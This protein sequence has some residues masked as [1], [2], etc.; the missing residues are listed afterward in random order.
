MSAKPFVFVLMPFNDA[1]TDIYKLGIKK[2]AEEAGLR[3][4]RVD[5]QLYSE[6]MLE[7]IYRQIDAAD[8]VVADMTGQN[9]NVFYEVGY[10]H[11]KGKLCI[12]LTQNAS[13]I[14]FDLKQHRHIVYGGQIVRLQNELATNLQWAAEQVKS[15]KTSGLSVNFEV[16]NE[17]LERN[18]FQATVSLRLLIDIE[19]T[20]E[21]SFG[22]IESVTLYHG[23]RWEFSQNGQICPKTKSDHPLFA[24]RHQLS[25]PLRR[26]GPKGWTQVIVS[27]RKR[28]HDYADPGKPKDEYKLAG[29]VMAR[30]A[31][32]NGHFDFDNFLDVDVMDIPF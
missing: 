14:P 18:E 7:R 23:M 28:V 24:E 15:D 8:I 31:T 20:R 10:A 5:E 19:N 1:F 11:A 26:L 6:S 9:P 25:P 2:T 13:D 32:A 16:K 27:G 22:E 17:E 3:A 12:L 29:R 30:I 4:E 21:V